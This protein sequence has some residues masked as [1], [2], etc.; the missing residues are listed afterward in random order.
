MC[1]SINGL[2]GVSFLAYLP[3]FCVMLKILSS[4]VS[5]DSDITY[6]SAVKFI[7]C[8]KLEQKSSFIDRHYFIM[9]RIDFGDFP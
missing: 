3:N 2:F 7:A 8:L 6:M 1:L 9:Y 4:K 5:V